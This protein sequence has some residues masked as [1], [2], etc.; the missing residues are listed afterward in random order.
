MNL[1]DILFPAKC[2]LCGSVQKV[3]KREGICMACAR[4]LP[5]VTE[6]L[7]KHCGKP[8]ADGTA[9]YCFDCEGRKS[10][11]TEGTAL[12]VYTEQM[13]KAMAAFKYGGS[14]GDSA[15]YGRELMKYRGA[16]LAGWQ[17]DYVVPVPL[18]W[19]KQWFRGYNQAE[20]VAEVIAEELGIPLLADCL[21]RKRYTRP[22]SG[23]DDKRRRQ[24]VQGA[25]GFRKA[26]EKEQLS[27][28]RI[29]LTDDI[30]TTGA[31]LEACG[32]LLLSHGV[33]NVYFACLCIGQDF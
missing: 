9:E 14:C 17:V 12:F 22:Q 24:N 28:C 2:P 1:L 26:F 25:F 11:L 23:L 21:E 13:K 3:G 20:L 32:T 7:C 27:G 4:K 15:I 19:K 18:H 33:K 31:T 10:S 6:P 5:L 8:I 29:L 16:K 30:Y